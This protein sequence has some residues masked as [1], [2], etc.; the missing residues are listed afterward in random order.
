MNHLTGQGC[1]VCLCKLV[2]HEGEECNDLFYIYSGDVVRDRELLWWGLCGMNKPLAYRGVVF[3]G[4]PS[5]T[6]DEFT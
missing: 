5:S 2:H 3:T 1:V 4:A 6:M